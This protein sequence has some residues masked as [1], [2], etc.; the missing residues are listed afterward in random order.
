MHKHAQGTRK[1]S[2]GSDL[3]QRVRGMKGSWDG[4]DGA[5]GGDDGDG[6]VDSPPYAKEVWR[7]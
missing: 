1:L 6:D 5:A 3:P 4:G 2:S 7:W